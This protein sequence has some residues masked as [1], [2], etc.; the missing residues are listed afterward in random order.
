[1]GF[2]PVP[3][4]S[5]GNRYRLP[6]GSFG[7]RYS[8]PLGSFGNR[9]SLPLGSWLLYRSRWSVALPPSPRAA[10]RGV[11]RTTCDDEDPLT[12]ALSPE[13]GGE[14]IGLSRPSIWGHEPGSFGNRPIL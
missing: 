8:L 1:M 7:N 4:A 13:D 2:D 5:F 10:G 14:G 9:H 12:L 11:F 3:L 6:L